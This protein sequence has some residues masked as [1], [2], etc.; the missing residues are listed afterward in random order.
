VLQSRWAYWLDIPVSIPAVCVYLGLLVSTFLLEK[1]TS[2]DEQR[3]A[4]M[5]IIG[6]SVLIAGAAI[7]FIS[8]QMFVIEAFCK[9]CLLAHACGF[10]AAILCL[11]SIP[12][13]RDPKM[14]AWS[15]N[16]QERGVPRSAFNQLV[17]F[18]LVGTLILIGGQF[19]IQKKRNLVVEFASA[20]TNK[21]PG[22]VASRGTNAPAA[23][24][25]KSPNAQLIAPRLLSLYGGE[26]LLQLD[27]T[28]MIGSPDATNVIVNLFDYNC[29]H[30]RMLHPMLVDV[31]KRFSDRL[32]IVCLPM[33]MD[34]GCNPYVPPKHPTFTNSCDY[35]KLSL[36]VWSADREAFSRF[37]NWLFST[38]EPAPVPQV[39]EYAVRLI[40]EEKLQSALTND[41]IN[42]EILKACS[43]HYTNW[44][45]AAGP[46]MP[47]IIIGPAISV[48][49]LNS[50]NH[51][52]I[53]LEKYLG[54]K[55]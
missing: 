44:Q 15:S 27:E 12:F 7:W 23:P 8:L 18:G 19:L 26:F 17:A 50:P 52:L 4:W 54:I 55:P 10:S 16:P 42:Q 9:F 31:Q 1:R 25:P 20:G 22:A 3:G 29:T 47:Q 40:G 39:R 49:A 51:L 46:A 34:R 28:P 36:A 24:N 2:P 11:K 35:A 48:G 32:G 41:W 33:P 43:I 45:A 21:A 13:A 53:L 38:P 37:D 14:A 30:C 6:L 5:L